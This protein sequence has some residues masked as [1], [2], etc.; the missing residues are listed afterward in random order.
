MSTSAKV[1]DQKIT[2]KYALYCGDAGVVLPDLPDA[3]VGFTI[4]SPPFADLYSYSDEAADLGNCADYDGFFT[5]FR[6]LAEHL[7]R[8]LMPG[9]LMAVHCMDLPTFKRS[10]EEIG[11][12]DFSGDLIRLF[13]S[14]GFVFHSRHC[15]WK[16][17]LVAAT[18]TKA[19]GLAHKQLVKDS[20]VSRTGIPDYLLAFRKPGVNPKP[21]PHP[22]GLTAYYGA[23]E[24]PRNL[25]KYLTM[26][27]TDGYGY[28][29]NPNPYDPKKD[30]R[31]HWIWQQYAS[32]VW[33]D[34]RQT[35]VLPY[36]GGR[37]KDDQRHVCPLQLDTIERCIELWS[38][39]GD[40]VLTP[41]MGVGSEVYVAVKRGRKGVGIELKRSYYR[42][43]LR[44]LSVLTRRQELR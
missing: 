14:L 27:N 3:S 44:N 9:R 4:Y 43:A 15:I 5:H 34:I 23:R 11:L 26:W 39:R 7:F 37:E 22:R 8:V 25:D 32:P 35:R 40:V 17:P 36:R 38:T 18:R 41:F 28:D 24:V 20:A 6:Y 30:K 10:G 19:V 42:Q 29:P 13:Q 1:R 16:D 31:S 33:F 2:K 21:I 12:R